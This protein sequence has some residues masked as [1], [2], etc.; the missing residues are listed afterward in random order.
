MKYK[1]FKISKES[2]PKVEITKV[3]ITD[4]DIIGDATFTLEDYIYEAHKMALQNGIRANVIMLNE[5]LAKTNGFVHHT[6][7]GVMDIPP[8]ICGLE[9]YVT[10]EIPE[11]FAFS[12][13]E[14]PLTTRE[15]I[16]GE[17]HKI[18]Y[19][20][21][22]DQGVRDFAE[23]VKNYYRHMTSKALP[24][25]VEYYIDQIEEEMLNDAE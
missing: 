15:T 22:Y 1:D 17:G 21:G 9:A 3:E 6:F 20:E 8:M 5:R 4:E 18:G 16:Y 7:G 12:M 10:D 25:T 2:V 13:L 14:A 24:A 19:A 11:E 23:R